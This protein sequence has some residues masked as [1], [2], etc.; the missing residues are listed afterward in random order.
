MNHA[1]AQSASGMTSW[2]GVLLRGTHLR[3]IRYR[4]SHRTR[5]TYSFTSLIWMVGWV[6]A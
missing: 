6:L 4:R 3:A 1:M 2:K 5:P